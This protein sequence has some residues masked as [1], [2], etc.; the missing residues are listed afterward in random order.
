LLQVHLYK[1]VWQGYQFSCS[2]LEVTVVVLVVVIMKIMI[3]SQWDFLIHF[4]WWLSLYIRLSIIWKWR[5]CT[6]KLLHNWEVCN[7]YRS[8]GFVRAGKAQ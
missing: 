6:I 5:N 3:F 1:A 4:D 7:L 2:F 8:A